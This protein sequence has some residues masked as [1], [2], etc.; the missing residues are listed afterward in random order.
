M[1]FLQKVCT[2]LFIGLMWVGIICAIVLLIHH[3]IS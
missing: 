3:I 1:D 2:A